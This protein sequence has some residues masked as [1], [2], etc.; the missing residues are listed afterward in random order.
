MSETAGTVGAGWQQSAAVTTPGNIGTPTSPGIQI[1]LTIVTFG[2]WAYVWTYRQHR[3]IKAYSGEGVGGGLGLVINMFV[4][5][6][7]PFLL[8][9][10]VQTKL[11]A[12]AGQPS[13]VSTGTG[14]WVLLPFVGSLVW[15]L[16]L[17][18]ALNKFWV[19]RGAT[20]A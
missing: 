16:K 12:R 10:E 7:T 6:V 4:G 15:Y 17:Q 14:A 8:A 18:D 20:P 3:D 11:Y 19:Q 1:L 5:I 9:N 13:P 2:I